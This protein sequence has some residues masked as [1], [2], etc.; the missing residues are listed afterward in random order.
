MI[1]ALAQRAGIPIAL[2]RNM[3]A[4]GGAKTIT[5]LCWKAGL[6]MRFA[7]D[8]QRRIGHI[9]PQSMLNARDG[10]DYPLSPQQ[11]TEQLTL[12]TG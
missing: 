11:L 6:T 12:F 4:S 10:V 7:M 8:V 5:A 1:E 3:A 9:P 2:V